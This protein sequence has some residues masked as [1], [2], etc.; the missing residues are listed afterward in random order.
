MTGSP[1]PDPY[2]EYYTAFHAFKVLS[3]RRPWPGAAPLRLT[4]V[5][6]KKRA[7]GAVIAQGIGMRLAMGTHSS[8]LASVYAAL[9]PVLSEMAAT[10]LDALD[11]A[12]REASTPAAPLPP[13]P[14]S[15][16]GPLEVA[17][18]YTHRPTADPA[19]A[20][21]LQVGVR[22]AATG[23]SVL[24]R[25]SNRSNAGAADVDVALYAPDGTVY[26]AHM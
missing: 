24:L 17:D 12:L 8:D 11:V 22:C 18:A 13:P 2:W 21:T 6:S 20:E 14:P 1:Y 26:A 25:C 23:W 5:S 9:T 15:W 10:S 3:A 7:Q 4:R 16:A 19:F